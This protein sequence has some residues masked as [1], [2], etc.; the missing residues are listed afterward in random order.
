[1][2]ESTTLARYLDV[3]I[4]WGKSKKEMCNYLIKRVIQGRKIK[5]LTQVG[6]NFLIKAV[7]HAIPSYIMMVFKVPKVVTRK[8]K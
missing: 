3:L 6:R 4:K 2:E 7:L 8:I 1:M 5:L